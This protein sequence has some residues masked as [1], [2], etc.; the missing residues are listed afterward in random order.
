[1]NIRTLAFL[2][3]FLFITP[4]AADESYIFARAPQL[5]PTITSKLWTPFIE[6]LSRSTNKKITLKIYHTRK[7]F[8]SDLHKGNVDFYFGNPGYGVV[9]HLRH[10]YVPLIRSNK[11][12]LEGIIVVKKNSGIKNI[13]QLNNQT[14]SFPD[15]TAFAASLFLRANIDSQFNIAYKASYSG[16]HDNTYRT[17]LIGKTAAGGGVARTLQQEDQQLREQLEIIYT[18]P[19]IQPHPIMAHPK[20]PK[21]IREAIQTTILDLDKNEDGKK[22]LKK[23]KLQQPVI[24]NYDEDYKSIE[25]ATL[26]MYHY[27]LN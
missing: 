7:E 6:A 5:S 25:I 1:M 27:L 24:A 22:L 8:E 21:E 16:S 26:K 18:T 3:A 12:K 23:I 13:R 9:G 17:V 15:R 14:I 19:G 4:L 20:V 2:F 10:G 11:K